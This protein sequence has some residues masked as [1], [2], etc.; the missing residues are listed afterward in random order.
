MAQPSARPKP[1]PTVRDNPY[2]ALPPDVRGLARRI[3]RINGIRGVSEIA[4][5]LDQTRAILTVPENYVPP[6]P[7]SQV[8]AGFTPAASPAPTYM[9]TPSPD[10]TNLE[11]PTPFLNVS[12]VPFSPPRYPPA[13]A[14]P[15]L[16]SPLPRSP[17]PSPPPAVPSIPAASPPRDIRIPPPKASQAIRPFLAR[18]EAL[19]RQMPAAPAARRFRSPAA[20]PPAQP[21][22]TPSVES[23]RRRFPGIQFRSPARAAP[24]A[25]PP[26]IIQRGPTPEVSPTRYLASMQRLETQLAGAR[27]AVAA[28]RSSTPA[29]IRAR[30]PSPSS[31]R[32]PTVLRVERGV[33]APARLRAARAAMLGRPPRGGGPLR[34]ARSTSFA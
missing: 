7:A 15:T 16:P 24:P 11:T 8:S 26:T 30:S 19:R 3:D 21:P 28:R 33:Y 14:S 6:T 17:V 22:T 29:V 23:L 32:S 10:A 13:R 31:R 5:T 25:Q 9:D 27:A 1:G 34:A 18:V 4:H 20:T 12:P 2:L